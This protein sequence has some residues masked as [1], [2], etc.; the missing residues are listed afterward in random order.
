MI[1]VECVCFLV[2]GVRVLVFRVQGLFMCRV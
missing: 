2:Q 1:G